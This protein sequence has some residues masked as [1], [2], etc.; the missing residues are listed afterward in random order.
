LPVAFGAVTA[1]AG[2]EVDTGLTGDGERPLATRA[3]EDRRWPFW[4]ALA[5]LVV[6]LLIT[7][8]LTLVSA[9]LNRDNEKQLL[10]LRA[11]EVGA[12]LTEVVPSIQT[13]V[14]SA[15]ALADATGGDVAKFKRF[16]APYVGLGAGQTFVSLSLWRVA[17]PGRGPVAVVGA[18]PALSSSI[19]RAPALFARASAKPTLSVTG[20]LQS[21][22]PRL[23]Y[24]FAG[25]APGP[26]AAYGESAVPPNRYAPVQ[27]NAAF[28]DIDYAVYLG[29]STNRA[30]L[31][32]ASVRHLPLSGRTRIVRTPVGDSSFT[33]A[34]G[35]R[36]PLGGSL[37]QH[38][39]PA[40][41]ILGALL[42]V[43]AGLVA[44]R[45]IDRRRG[46]ERLA[47]RLEEIAEENRR[48]YAEQRGIAQTLQHALLPENLPQLPGIQASARYEAGA[49]GVE[50]GGDWYDL[51]ALDDRRLLLVV[52]DVSGKGLRAAT[53]MAALRY[54]IHAYA[55]QGDPPTELLRKLSNLVNVKA[56]RQ[57]ATVL[58]ALVDV[59]ARTVS[60]TS[61]GHLPPLMITAQ[62]S[63][64]VQSEVGLPV[65][66]DRAASYASTTIS[67]P[68][69]AT[70]LAYTDGLVERRGES[71]D[72]GLER[73]R[74]RASGNHASLDELLTRVLEDLRD[75]ASEDDTAIAGIRWM[76]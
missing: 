16:A 11:R 37:P 67:A 24:A 76:T 8:V 33:V 44:A 49:H 31:I 19:Q 10:G 14:A 26:F 64:F 60:V 23:G 66:V 9:K 13:P 1:V 71:I 40:I 70:L 6:G 2:R 48:L 39:A 28:S 18:A 53:T 51:I 59:S 74:A 62:G 15:A 73:L 50:I 29:P 25:A 21:S 61:A 3:G 20:F 56:D 72:A 58:C 12:V 46:A 52:G 30:D 54:A 68:P 69:G 5:V 38:V 17:D 75:D 55:A 34:V 65:G 36:S 42:S 7:A 22:A 47:G 27:S 35:A 57:L 32:I 4:P 63:R 41:A 45:L 43:G